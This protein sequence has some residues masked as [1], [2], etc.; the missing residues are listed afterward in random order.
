MRIRLPLLFISA[1]IAIFLVSG[2][3]QSQTRRRSSAKAKNAKMQQLVPLTLEQKKMVA[4]L[5]ERAKSIEITYQTDPYKFATAAETFMF[6]LGAEMERFPSGPIKT[7]LIAMAYGYRDSGVL[8]GMLTGTSVTNSF[9]EAQAAATGKDRRPQLIEEI[10]KR[11]R[12]DVMQIGL[13]Q[14]QRKIFNNAANLKDKL[15]FL[16]ARTPTE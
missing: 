14:A 1:L 16:L 4:D 7:H 6:A 11:W 12:L 15:S 8:W 9:Y 5:I 13:N 10:G 2:V 3:T